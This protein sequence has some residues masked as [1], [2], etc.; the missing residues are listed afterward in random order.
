MSDLRHTLEHF[1]NFILDQHNNIDAEIVGANADFRLERL[2]VYYA[3]YGLR[4][5]EALVRAYPALKKYMGEE[6]FDK[7]GYLYIEKYPSHHFSIRYFGRQFSEFLATQPEITPIMVELAKFEWAL[8]S[9]LDA[10][11]GPQLTLPDLAALPPEAWADLILI[12]HP[13]TS[14]LTLSYP[15]PK[16][17]KSLVSDAEQP[18]LSLEEETTHWLIWRFNQAAH[19][20]FMNKEQLALIQAIQTGEPFSEICVNLCEYLG[21]DKVVAFAAE[22]LRNWISE[23]LFSQFGTHT[24]IDE[25]ADE[26]R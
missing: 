11:D 22:N 20:L 12:T 16:L 8:A 18:V 14:L 1:Q 6:L 2:D 17:W 3:A 5:L 15:T 25:S 24:G 21:E 9:A 10:A 4:L 7:L 13:S 23:G 19:Y 26:Q